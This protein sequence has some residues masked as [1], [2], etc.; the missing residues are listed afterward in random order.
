MNDAAHAR[1][2]LPFPGSI[3][4]LWRCIGGRNILSKKGREYQ[5]AA[6]QYLMTQRPL[7]RFDSPVSVEIALCPPSRRRMDIDNRIKPVLDALQEA[8]VL[9]D[10]SLVHRLVVTW[11]RSQEVADAGGCV[12]VVTLAGAVA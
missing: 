6:Q 2:M 7:P 10:D 8:G 1:L 12:C 11:D 5:A 9:A 3:N 4:G